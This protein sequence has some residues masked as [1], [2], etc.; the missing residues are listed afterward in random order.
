MTVT[1]TV[2]VTVTVPGVGE[3]R[4]CITRGSRERVTWER[5][6][7]VAAWGAWGGEPRAQLEE[8]GRGCC[9]RGWSAWG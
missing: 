4:W 8:R 3:G 1:A 7:E 2:T 9:G 5:L 6:G